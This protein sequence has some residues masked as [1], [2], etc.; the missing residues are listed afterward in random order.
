MSEV[1]V[2]PAELRYVAD[3]QQNAA[4][5]EADKGVH[6]TESV[7]LR[8]KLYMSH[9]PISGPSNEAIN[10]RTA[11][12]EV[13]GRAMA[14]ACRSLSAGL[15]EAADLYTKTDANSSEDLDKQ[16]RRS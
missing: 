1:T 13:A 7:N 15:H 10:Y 16:L 5:D 2:D 11:V 9:G 14:E 12:R 8:E 4:A 6:A 3:T